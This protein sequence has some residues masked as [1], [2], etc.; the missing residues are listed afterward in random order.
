M[1]K[2]RG[3]IPENNPTQAPDVSSRLFGQTDYDIPR[4]GFISALVITVSFVAS[5]LIVPN[6]I[7]LPGV[8]GIVMASI[9]GGTLTGAAFAGTHYF[10]ENKRGLCKA[11]GI[12]FSAVSVL[13]SIFLFI[14]N[15]QVM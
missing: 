15:A 4:F 14:M 5:F 3:P 9:V 2:R 13:A 8:P 1:A 7:T 6:V 12:E 11:F 10:R